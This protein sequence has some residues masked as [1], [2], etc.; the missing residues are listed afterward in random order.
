MVIFVTLWTSYELLSVTNTIEWNFRFFD[1][2]LEKITCLVSDGETKSLQ[3]I[4]DSWQP[5]KTYNFCKTII[6]NPE[7][8]GISVF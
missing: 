2:S 5:L 8:L 4:F 3:P 7:F 1:G 6:Q